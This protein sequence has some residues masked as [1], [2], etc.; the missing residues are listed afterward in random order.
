MAEEAI[1]VSVFAEKRKAASIWID[2][3]WAIAAVLPGTPE[4]PAMTLVAREEGV[5]RY[6]IGT[7]PVVLA[8]S[9]TM[10]YRD[11]LMSGAPKLWVVLRPHEADGSISLV[12]VTADSSEGEGHTQAGSDLVDAVP[13]HP[14][15]AAFI[16]SFVDEHHVEREFFKRKREKADP[17]ALGYRKKHDPGFLGSKRGEE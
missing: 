7:Y 13:M 8:S 17:N 16:A 14:E 12:V 5:E 11:N 2:H 6:F 15:I 3:T 4:T 1:I 10:H 9:E